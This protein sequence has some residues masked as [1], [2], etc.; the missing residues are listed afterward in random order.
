SHLVL[1]ELMHLELVLEARNAE[2][3]LLFTT[4]DSCS[5]K[6]QHSLRSFS[7]DLENKGIPKESIS[8][9]VDSLFHG[10][11]NQVYNTPLDLFIEDRIYTRFKEIKPIQFLSLLRIVKEGITAT[12]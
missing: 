2:D 12:T 8:K 4:N 9:F 7:K 10:I 11:N 5:S 6:F 3:N 1:H